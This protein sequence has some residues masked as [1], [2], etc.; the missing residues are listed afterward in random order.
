MNNLKKYLL[1]VLLVAVVFGA[2]YLNYT[3]GINAQNDTLNDMISVEAD[4]QNTNSDI[5]TN[6]SVG[7]DYFA[8]YKTNREDTR[9]KEIAYLEEIITDER[10]DKETLADA[11]SQKLAIVGSM[12]KELT[13]EGVLNAKGFGETLV[14]VSTGSVNVVLKNKEISQEQAAQILDIVQTETNEP[15]KNIKIILQG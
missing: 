8:E 6:A 13:L 3:L 15:A 7:M 4:S 2:G 9:Q 11:Q 5:E 14:T 12:E 10:S 1:I